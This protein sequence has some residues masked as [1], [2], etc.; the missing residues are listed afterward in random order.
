MYAHARVYHTNVYLEF[1]TFVPSCMIHTNTV[2]GV[3]ETKTNN[4]GI[5]ESFFLIDFNPVTIG[6]SLTNS[7]G[8]LNDSIKMLVYIFEPKH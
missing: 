1:E 8:I 2:Q 3:M 4:N 6:F 7:Y 5:M